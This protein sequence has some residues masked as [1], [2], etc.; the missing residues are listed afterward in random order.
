MADPDRAAQLVNLDAERLARQCRGLH[1][2]HLRAARH[3]SSRTPSCASARPASRACRTPRSV[4]GRSSSGSPGTASAC[5][6]SQSIPALYAAHATG[7]HAALQ[8]RGGLPAGPAVQ[9]V[10]ARLAATSAQVLVM[11]RQRADDLLD[12]SSRAP[13]GRARPSDP[14][15]R[16]STAACRSPHGD[17]DLRASWAEMRSVAHHVDKHAVP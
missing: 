8:S 10:P 13:H 2:A 3:T 16:P 4:S 12:V 9:P 5:R 15:P 1:R 11:A 7:E 6:N 14:P 17:L